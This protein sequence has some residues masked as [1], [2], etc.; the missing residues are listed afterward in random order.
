MFAAHPFRDKNAHVSM[1]RFRLP[2]LRFLVAAALEMAVSPAAADPAKYR[3][4]GG[5]SKPGDATHTENR[6]TL[7]GGEFTMSA[8]GQNMQGKMKMAYDAVENRKVDA[9]EHGQAT[10]VAIFHEKDAST[11]E[12]EINGQKIPHKEVSPMDGVTVIRRKTGDNWTDSLKEGT[13]SAKQKKRLHTDQPDDA[14]LLYPAGEIAV[15][16]TWTVPAS[17]LKRLFGD[18]MQD[19][20]GSAHCKL[21]R[22]ENF[23]GQHCAVIQLD[24]D[25]S[26]TGTDDSNSA[27][28]MTL[29][30]HG[31]VY[32]SLQRPVDMKT[33]LQG[34]LKME[35][36]VGAGGAATLSV[37]GPFV[38]A[39]KTTVTQ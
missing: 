29:N 39:E 35:G 12:M 21:L 25:A 36:S 17:S 7:T 38:V 1:K 34:T 4:N 2:L 10:P 8:G 22:V 19:M 11:Q 9:A 31:T 33:D 30:V 15:G 24:M 27:M 6:M 23:G 5:E 14:T 20:N 13:P 16:D 28:K 26:G 37:T 3:L 18:D 32:R